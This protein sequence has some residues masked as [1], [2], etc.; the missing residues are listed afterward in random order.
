MLINLDTVS[1]TVQCLASG[2]HDWLCWGQ[3]SF[4]RSGAAS[5]AGYRKDWYGIRYPAWVFHGQLVP[6]TVKS[7]EL[8]NFLSSP[9]QMAPCASQSSVMG[10]TMVT[11]PLESG[12]TCISQRTFFPFSRRFALVTSPPVTV[13]AWSRRVL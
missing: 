11:L 8:D 13:N 10:N 7:R 6:E 5:A 2:R 4:R 1:M 3:F 9:V 12:M